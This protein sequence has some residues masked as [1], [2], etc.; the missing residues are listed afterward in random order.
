MSYGDFR[1]AAPHATR[2]GLLIG[3]AVT[4]L[5]A[6]TACGDA[7]PRAGQVEPDARPPDKAEFSGKADA[8]AVARW[9]KKLG[10]PAF[11]DICDVAGWYNDGSCESFCPRKDLD[12]QALEDRFKYGTIGSEAEGIPY[13]VWQ[14]LPRAFPELLPATGAA[15]DYSRFGFHYEAGH[16]VPVGFSKQKQFGRPLVV[17]TN[18]AACHSGTYRLGDSESPRLVLGAPAH[19]A[20]LQRYVRFLQAAA[21]QPD[22]VDRVSQIIESISDLNAVERV[23]YRAVVRATQ[24]GIRALDE[25]YAWTTS[26]PDWGPG[27]I[28]PFN[29]V[30]F[31]HLDLDPGADSSVGN[32]DMT[33][34]WML[35]PRALHWDGLNRDVREVVLSSAIGTGASEASLPVA[36]LAEIQSWLST[37][38]APGY[39]FSVD[40]LQA[41]Q[42]RLLFAKHCAEC[43]GSAGPRTGTVVP[44]AEVGTDGARLTMWTQQAADRYNAYVTDPALEFSNFRKT[45]GYVA[46]PLDGLWMRAP[47]L[48]NGSVPTLADL[49]QKTQE[50]PTAFWRGSDIFDPE[51]VWVP[52][53]VSRDGFF[54]L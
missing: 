47:Y 24:K 34:L 33:S 2:M 15:V 38:E 42:G 5:V 43:H 16:A 30:K 35:S 13:W 9:C 46:V 27:R 21:A 45:D 22:F 36:Q 48:H 25:R 26:R 23:A 28:D 51:R 54:L 7:S 49:L 37:L 11:C 18:C 17:A 31:H 3:L 39:P 8:A 19:G 12:C 14:A 53:F 44:I 50:R 1:A 52:G 32:S 20:D 6:T 4:S 29:P 10:E 41:E 40:P